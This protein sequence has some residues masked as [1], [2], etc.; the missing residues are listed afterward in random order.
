[1]F[2]PELQVVLSIYAV[3]SD[4]EFAEQPKQVKEM[5][6]L[7]PADWWLYEMWAQLLLSR[8]GY[9]LKWRQ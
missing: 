7:T 6:L 9:E 4:K 2:S 1:M 8:I 5:F 3:S